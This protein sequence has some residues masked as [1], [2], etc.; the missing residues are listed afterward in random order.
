[1]R[2]ILR[3]AAPL[4]LAASAAAAPLDEEVA[5]VIDLF[6]DLQFDRALAA[7]EAIGNKHPGHPAG[8]FY[9]SIVY[10]QLFLAEEPKTAETLAAFMR[11]NDEAL[12]SAQ[13]LLPAN[14]AQGHYFLGAAHGFRARVLAARRRYLRAIPHAF[15]GVRHLREAL[16]LDPGLEDAYLGLGMFHYFTARLPAGAKPFAYL[17]TGD[18]GNRE[19]GLSELRRA[20]ERGGPAKMEARSVLSAVY[21]SD[22]ER[23]W[24]V[25]EGLLK[26]LMDR[27]PRNPLYRLRRVYVAQRRLDWDKAVSLA[28]PDGKWIAA[29]DPRLR[30]RSREHARY[31]AAESLLLSGRAE[32]AEPLLNAL[33]KSQLIDPM[34]GWLALRQ[35]NRLDARG[36]RKEA[37]AAYRRVRGKPQAD[38][39]AAFLKE[40]YPGGP[41]AVKPWTGLETPR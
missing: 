11:A 13:A 20:A 35:G 24:D 39:A 10:Y 41:R 22:S 3:I 2:V 27:Y 5:P 21:A 6:Y 40:P 36:R 38:M 1:M 16:A 31:R 14:P 12:A 15:Q 30:D 9:R 17:L 19:R 23:D 25:A 33:E 4:L 32:R 29:L 34:P 8:P 26:D 7:A 18:W 28:D 37:V